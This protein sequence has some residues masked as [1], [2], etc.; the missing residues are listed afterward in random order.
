MPTLF[1]ELREGELITTS[2][3]AWH[4]RTPH[5]LPTQTYL[6]VLQIGHDLIPPVSIEAHTIS[7][8]VLGA[9]VKVE[10]CLHRVQ[11]VFYE[12]TSDNLTISIHDVSSNTQ[13][14]ERQDVHRKFPD[15]MYVC[16]DSN[17]SVVDS[18]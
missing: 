14:S 13:P 7:D 15:D 17:I 1:Q 18:P 8:W 11:K 4:I 5:K 16:T 6:K 2:T 3:F 10:A 12:S 9:D